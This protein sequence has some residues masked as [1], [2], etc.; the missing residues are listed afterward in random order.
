MCGI[1][2][3]V[4]D[5]PTDASAQ[6]G[7]MTAALAHRGPDGEG[8]VALEP[9]RPR[10]RPASGPASAE[11]GQRARVWLGHRRLAI[12]DPRGTAQPLADEDGS[13]WVS[14]NGELYNHAELRRELTA[15]GHRLRHA[16]D[17][18]VL[19]HLWD[20]LSV[21][22]P[23]AL[24]GMFAIA[25]YDVRQDT[26]LL[27]RDRF[28]QKPLFVWETEGRLAFASELQAL[29]T[30]PDFPRRLPEDLD[31]AGLASYLALGYVP[32]PGTI[33]K[34]VSSLMPGELLLRRE[35]RSE[36][37]RYWRPT[38]RADT[39]VEPRELE[40]E[41]DAL[42]D[43]AVR[44]RLMADVPLGAFL[45]GGIDSTLIVG[46]MARAGQAPL[47][48]TLAAE[49]GDDE[50]EPAGRIAA[51]LGAQLRL[52]EARPRPLE[53]MR[54]LA[55]HYGQP[56]AD[57][58]AVPTAL[59]SAGARETLTVALTGDGGDELFAGYQRYVNQRYGRWAAALPSGLRGL[60]AAGL[61]RAPLGRGFAGRLADFLSV[62]GPAIDRGGAPSQLCHRRWRRRLLT[63]R[64]REALADLP[65]RARD[66]FA[67]AYGEAASTEPLEAWLEADQQ[68][69]LADDLQVKVDIASMSVGLETRAPFLDHR[70]ASVANRLPLT[71]KL[72]GGESKRYLRQLLRRRHPELSW[73]AAGPKRGFGLP[74]ARWL[75]GPE[76]ETARA[77]LLDGDPWMG[78]FQRPAIERL[79]RAH[80][81]GADHAARLWQLLAWRLWLDAFEAS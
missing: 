61:E 34:G 13:I 50:R 11:S 52:A 39:L 32:S 75:R 36:R 60:A 44:A 26:L 81:A 16:G 17:T 4:F 1:C 3:L 46:A 24:V 15:R 80:Q 40:D 25:L 55:A 6:L 51:S 72:G 18:E 23:E 78:I 29:W 43:E 45:S 19:P 30:L 5:E 62:A 22:L 33:F 37:H 63:P 14:F 49:G 2:G 77:L 70:L 58:S 38:V 68:L 79:W 69:Y 47:A 76:S 20:E 31:P 35:G 7:R 41:L 59:V 27:V 57:Y 56:F 66:R 28:G 74:L 9:G 42:V 53:T 10:E 71:C 67:A 8:H 48:V 12:V 64:W 54:Q 73:V 65:L 21:A